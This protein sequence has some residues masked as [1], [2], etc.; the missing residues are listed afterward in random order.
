MK[1]YTAHKDSPESILRRKTARRY[2]VLLNY[3]DAALEADFHRFYATETIPLIH[4]TFLL[5]VPVWAICLLLLFYFIPEQA[6]RITQI[7]VL[8]TLPF[9]L[10][11]V[12]LRNKPKWLMCYQPLALLSNIITGL[13][14][15]YICSYLESMSNNI[16][17]VGLMLMVFIGFYALRLRARYAIVASLV[18]VSSYAV[19]ISQHAAVSHD[20]T[21]L[22]MLALLVLESFACLA[23]YVSES[24]YRTIFEQQY[25]ISEQK[26]QLASEH[27]RAEK[28]LLNILPPS[29]ATRLQYDESVIAD[30]FDNIGLLFADIVGFTELS[31]KM[32]AAALVTLLN[33]LFSSF[34]DLVSQAGLE[35]IKTIGDAYMVAAGMPQA[36]TGSLAALADFALA[37]QTTITQYNAQHDTNLQL[38]IG[39]HA[40]P[41]VAGVIGIKKFVY[42]VWG[43]AVNIASRMESHG[44]AGRIQVSDAVYAQLQHAYNFKPRGI[45]KIKGKGEMRTW[46][47]IA[48]K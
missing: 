8:L 44:V 12:W 30:Q 13:L 11:T 42:D 36:K 9:I 38:R 5:S 47:L 46:F 17:V 21:I 26:T 19:Y 2:P 4:A 22:L 1:A 14:M 40:G 28:L 39:M 35:K 16:M 15:L 20:E 41:V 10:A 27:E 24:T 33:E 25:L 7:S 31:A 3:R 29:I 45:I 48:A 43:D 23:A 6:W 32:S 18:L 37:M 34:D